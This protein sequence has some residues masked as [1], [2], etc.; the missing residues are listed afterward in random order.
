[1][2]VEVDRLGFSHARW[3]DGIADPVKAQREIVGTH[4][5]DTEG[6]PVVLLRNDWE[7]GVAERENPKVKFLTTSPLDQA[8]TVAAVR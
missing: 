1:M 7:L 2:N 5:D 8:G 4:V 6:H 3:L